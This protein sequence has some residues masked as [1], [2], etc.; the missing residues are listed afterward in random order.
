[1]DIARIDGLDI[2][3]RELGDGPAV[4]L[5]HGWP[6]S[7]YLFRDVIEPLAQHHRVIAPDL[8]GFGASSKPTGIRYDFALFESVIDGL[9]DRA[10]AFEV[11]LLG[12]DLGGPIAVHWALRN[13]DRVTSVALLNTILYP[14][15]SAEV[16]EFVQRML[17]PVTAMAETSPE[18]LAEFMRLGVAEGHRMSLDAIA[19]YLSPFATDD[20]RRALAAAAIGLDLA[21]FAQIGAEMPTLNVPLRLIYGEQDRI[22]PDIATTAQRIQRDCPQAQVTA[23]PSCGHFL[24]EQEPRLVGEMLTEF[25]AAQMAESS[26]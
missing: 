15:F 13:P 1:M 20:D 12:H 7:S 22:L 11:M 6:T 26:A 4:L 17:D 2:A 18:S 10:G 9:L 19:E 5:L 25:F 23:L 14:E 8:P 3:Y 21:G 24:L 16:V